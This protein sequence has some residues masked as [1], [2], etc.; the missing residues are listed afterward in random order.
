MTGTGA[1]LMMVVRGLRGDLR[2]RLQ[3]LLGLSGKFLDTMG[4][5]EEV[6]RAAMLV[7][8]GGRFGDTHPADRIFETGIL[9][10]RGFVLAALTHGYSLIPGV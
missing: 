6:G 4:A 10:L 9:R 3:V 1:I 2:G 7:A 8:V 5:A